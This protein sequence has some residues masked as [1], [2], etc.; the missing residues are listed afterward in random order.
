MD[1]IN[2]Y[3]RSLG[4]FLDKKVLPVQW[5]Y[6]I[7]Y[8]FHITKYV[9]LLWLLLYSPIQFE[10]PCGNHIAVIYL[11]VKSDFGYSLFIK[12]I[13]DFYSKNFVAKLKR[14]DNLKSEKAIALNNSGGSLIVP[15]FSFYNLVISK[16]SLTRA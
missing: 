1:F 3:S 6:L 11:Y 15:D 4:F 8:T 13:I 2:L 7:L 10:Q 9:L 5:S 14:E 12:V 16:H